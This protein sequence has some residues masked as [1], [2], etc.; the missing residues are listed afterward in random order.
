MKTRWLMKIVPAVDLKYGGSVILGL[1]RNRRDTKKI[2]Y[3]YIG[4]LLDQGA[5][6]LQVYDLDLRDRDNYESRAAVERICSMGVPVMLGGGLRD[7]ER[8]R[9]AAQ[10]VGE[11]GKVII[12]PRG[13]REEQFLKELGDEFGTERLVLA[14][15][16]NEKEGT[17]KTETG[18]H[19]YNP[20]ITA[21]NR[22]HLVS[23]YLLGSME[24][25]GSGRGPEIGL[26]RMAKEKIEEALDRP[27]IASGGVASLQDVMG[28]RETGIYGLVIGTALWENRFSLRDAMN[29][30][31][32]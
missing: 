24:R 30:A 21:R 20:F 27:V 6:M 26:Y 32:G 18:T 31:K 4:G 29:A 1:R 12:G 23:G 28:V 11:N 7:I 8:A 17:G 3:D 19:I 25:E 10:L 5:E 13:I 15:D 22:R 2:P 9:E 16:W 14:L